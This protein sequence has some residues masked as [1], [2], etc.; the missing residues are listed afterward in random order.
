MKLT[1]IGSGTGYINAKRRGPCFLLEVADQKLLFDCGWGCPQGLLAAGIDPHS[2]NHIFIS[3]SHADHL[4]SLMTLIQSR[5]IAASFHPEKT[6]ASK[7]FLHGYKGF[8]KDFRRL[9]R[10]MMPEAPQNFKIKIHEY[11]EDSRR[12]K[13]FD[14]QSLPVKHTDFFESVAFRIKA[15]NKNFVYSGDFAYNQNIISLA[16]KT[17]LLLIDASVPPQMYDDRGAFPTHLAPQQIGMIAHE[18]KAKKVVLFHLYDLASDEQ[19]IK[20]VKKNFTGTVIVPKDDQQI[21]I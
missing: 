8:K 10:M 20:A 15:E 3:H 13:G 12:F 1:I 16:K 2:L 9:R 6:V 7:L 17:D 5:L 11:R 21:E 19:T 14:I 4:A 18:A